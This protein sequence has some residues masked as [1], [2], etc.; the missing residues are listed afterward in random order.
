M[1]TISKR[2]PASMTREELWAEMLELS[3]L[4]RVATE[5]K[6]WYGITDAYRQWLA[7]LDANAYARHASLMA[8]DSKRDQE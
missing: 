1:H 2:D 8:E 7:T 3:T 4:M 5:Q 6:H